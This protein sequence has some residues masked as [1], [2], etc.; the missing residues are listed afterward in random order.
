MTL[1]STIKAAQLQAR[2]SKD[3]IATGVLTTLIGE[4]V[5]VGKSNGNRETTDAEVIA[6]VK[7]FITNA[8][9]TIK[10]LEAT[11]PAVATVNKEIE[12]LSA[13]L[14]TQMSDERLELAI[15]TAATETGATTIKDMGKVMKFLKERYEGTYDGAKASAMIKKLLA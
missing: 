9:E 15:A 11:N 7:K 4:A 13:F 5:N 8:Q 10:I 1:L 14:P 12:I 3:T 6:M 2:K